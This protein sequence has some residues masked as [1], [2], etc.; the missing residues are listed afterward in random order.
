F[1]YQR[2]EEVGEDPGDGEGDEDGLQEAEDLGDEVNASHGDGTDEDDGE[3]GGGGPEGLSL[4]GSGVAIVFHGWPAGRMRWEG[5]GSK[6]G[7]QGT[8]VFGGWESALDVAKEVVGGGA[9]EAFEG[10]GEVEGV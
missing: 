5:E 9:V 3:S 4:P 8:G 10:A 2:F 6:S 1:A 7:A